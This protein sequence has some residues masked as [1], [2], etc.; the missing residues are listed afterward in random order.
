[1]GARTGRQYIEGLKGRRNIWLDGQ[2]VEDVTTHPAF[3][4]PIRAIAHLYDLQHR[5]DLLDVMTFPSPTTGNPVGTSYL[6][7]RTQEDLIK[8]RKMHQVWARATYGMM[9]RST[10]FMN[11]QVMAMAIHREFFAR[12]DPR[13]GQNIAAYYEHIREN[14]LFLTHA[15]IDPQI[16]RSKN[17][18]QQADPHLV[19]GI[20]GEN[21]RGVIVRGCKM[22]ATSAPFADELF[23]WPFGRFDP[24]ESPYAIVFALPMATEG[25]H[26]ICREPFARPGQG[27][28]HPLSSRFDEMDTVVIFE[29]VLLPWERVFLKNDVRL[30]NNMYRDTHI[31]NYTAHQTAARLVTKMELVIGILAELAETVGIGGFLHVQE[32]LGEVALHAE[33]IRG[34]VRAGEADAWIREDGVLVPS[35]NPLQCT[36][37]WGPEFYPRA[38]EILQILGAGGLLMSPA[39]EADLRGPMGDRIRK[40]YA[41]ARGDTERR[42]RLFKLAWDLCGSDFGSRHVLYERYYAGDPVRLKAG[43]YHEVDK[44]Q[45]LALVEELIGKKES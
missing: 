30:F 8:R 20:V 11:T 4:E 13:F 25:L 40:Y 36:R 23:V 31:R 2:R 22:I 37:L 14:D 3:A 5:P 29:D 44:T 33:T 38:I 28:A 7:P 6:I 34:L 10:D 45:C 12:N 16:D 35:F 42:L 24:E 19:L 9:G 1:M 17:R 18:A 26:F 41:G 43:F 15:L 27:F 39:S 21:E 32:K